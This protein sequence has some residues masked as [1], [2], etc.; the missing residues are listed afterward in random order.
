MTFQEFLNKISDFFVNYIFKPFEDFNFVRDTIDI[1]LLTL[2]IFGV[3][4]FIRKRRAGKLAIGLIFIVLM[5]IISNLFG[6]KAIGLVLT[7]FY[8]V[9]IIAIL[10][11]FQPELR[12]ALEKVGNTSI[13]SRIKK[14]ASSENR[15]YI[16]FVNESVESIC[17]AVFDMSHDK[18]GALIVIERE[19]KLG[20]YIDTG[21]KLNA[22][23]SEELLKNIFFKNAPLHDGAVIIRDLRVC[24]AGC[25]LRISEQEGLDS[26]LGTRHRAAIGVSE[27]S[28]AAVIVVSEETGTV[29]LAT[30]GNI[31][32]GLDRE[33]LK[34][35]LLLMLMTADDKEK[36]KEKDKNDKGETED[37]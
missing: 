26:E 16:A 35:E 8:Q 19:T 18:V 32:R 25:F 6:M 37:V 13:I 30:D 22:A 2:L 17:N 10:I 31:K 12:A 21:V 34:R 36:G 3:Y 28:D 24:A 15:R 5:T 9:G 1:L 29:S 27:V 33:T 23:L 4:R 7:N 20:E 11:V 14:I